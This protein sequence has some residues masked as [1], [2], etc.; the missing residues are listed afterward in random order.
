MT[1][2]NC[3][4]CGKPKEPGDECPYC[5][6]Y[7]AKA[8]AALKKEIERKKEKQKSKPQE[9]I[10]LLTECKACKKQISINAPACPHCGEPQEKPKPAPK[11]QPKPQRTVKEEWTRKLTGKEI[12]FFM[13]V[14]IVILSLLI[15]FESGEESHSTRKK[16]GPKYPPED[17]VVSVAH[18]LVKQRLKAPST[19]KFDRTY[20]R[21]TK[22]K[23]NSWLVQ[24][25]VDSQNGFGAMIR[26][27]WSIKLAPHLGEC[28]DYYLL[29][30]WD[31]EMGPMIYSN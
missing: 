11:Q 29:K 20:T 26:S 22:L 16:K 8:E 28:D 12:A 23:D 3:V 15:A 25:N 6:V 9:E 27:N 14:P 31:V 1:H 5:G 17:A 4:K 7:Y 21:K 19:A 24:G 18:H 13:L 2:K 30:C 10:S